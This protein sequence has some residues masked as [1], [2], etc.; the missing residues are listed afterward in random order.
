MLLVIASLSYAHKSTSAE[1]HKSA[2][3]SEFKVNKLLRG[4]PV[5]TSPFLGERSKFEAYDLVVNIPSVNQDV[6]LLEQTKKL[7][8]LMASKGIDFP[9]EPMVDLSGRLEAAA[10]YLNRHR[11][12]EKDKLNFDL[13]GAELDILARIS[14]YTLVFFNV[15]YDKDPT[16]LQR[17]ANSRLYVD[18]AFFT[19]GNLNECPLYVSGGQLYLPF[20]Q[21]SSNMISSPLTQ[22]VGR[23]RQ[24]ALVIGA[25]TSGDHNFHAAIYGFRGDTVIGGRN[26][27]G[28]HGVYNFKFDDLSGNVGVGVISHMAEADGM[29]STGGPGGF[30]ANPFPAANVGFSGFAGSVNTGP[31]GATSNVMRNRVPGI[32][33]QSRLGYKD[34]ALVGE[35]VFAAR[36]FNAADMIFNGKAARPLAFHVEGQY[37]FSV[38]D[39]PANAN[40]GYDLT[41]Q[42]LALNV[43]QHRIIGAINTAIWP[44]T[45]Q[46]LEVRHDINYRAGTVAGRAGAN[47]AGSTFLLTPNGRSA[48]TVTLQVGYYF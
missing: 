3:G 16:G 8:N 6:R 18:K 43:P 46:S 37:E 25:K 17:N 10:T 1:S 33:V 9:R 20:G 45:I 32:N 12:T 40:I 27:G 2:K 4:I 38:M 28:I 47:P 11:T 41:S 26:Q 22:A 34:F 44:S 36:R 30:T 31:G 13:T 7:E 21:Y 14:R 5:V 23:V 29:L 19:V 39:V 48:T 42:A 35:L 24:R 15:A